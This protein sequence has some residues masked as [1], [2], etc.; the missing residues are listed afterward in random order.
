M[1]ADTFLPKEYSTFG[2]C[3]YDCG[4]CQHRYGKQSQTDE[5]YRYIYQSFKAVFIHYLNLYDGS[6]AKEY[7]MSL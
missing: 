7:L 2:V 3:L 5:G 1:Y 6:A 4:N